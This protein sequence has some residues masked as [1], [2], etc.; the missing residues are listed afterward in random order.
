MATNTLQYASNKTP[1]KS[2]F[3]NNNNLLVE[4]SKLDAFNLTNLYN[5]FVMNL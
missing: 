1:N 4:L 3:A 5:K 2:L